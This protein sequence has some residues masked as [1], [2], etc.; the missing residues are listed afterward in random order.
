MADGVA[1]AVAWIIAGYL[2]IAPPDDVAAVVALVFGLAAASFFPAIVLGIF[3]KRM[4]K[5]GAIAGMII[6]LGLTIFYI[7]KFKF[8]LIGSSSKA[9]LWFGI[10]PE[11]FG[12][13][14][15]LVNFA[16]ALLISRFTPPP[17]LEVQELVEEIRLPS[18]AGEAH[19]H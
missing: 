18:G 14:G 4:N 5:E 2:G 16:V 7:L 15:M 12:F 19:N 17:P 10:S 8:G 6:G 9:D 11:G 13:V 3:S 1:T